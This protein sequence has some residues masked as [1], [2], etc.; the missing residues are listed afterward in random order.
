LEGPARTGLQKILMNMAFI[1]GANLSGRVLSLLLHAVL[2]RFFGP[3]GLGGYF[4]A[5]AVAVY[6]VFIVDFGLSPRLAREGAIGPGR[7]AEEYADALG[8][9]LFTGGLA[10]LG[11]ISVYF[12]LPYEDWVRELCVLLG[13]ASIIRS[14]SYLNESVCRARER[15]DLEAVSGLT[16]AVSFVAFSMVLIVRGFPV[17]TVGFALIAAN[18]LQLVISSILAR[19]LVALGAHLPPRWSIGRAALPYA[20]TSLTFLAFA[21]IDVLL[22]SLIETQE[23]VGRY[24][25]LSRLLL[26]AGSVGALAGAALLPT[27]SRLYGSVKVERFRELVSESVRGVLLLSGFAMLGLI[28]VA[29]PLIVGIYGEAFADLSPMLQMGS[30]YLVF[31]LTVAVLGVI[32]TAVGRQGDRARSMLIGLAVTVVLVL[33]LVPA[34]GILGAVAAMAGSEFVFAGCLALYVG[35]TIEWKKHLRAIGTMILASATSVSL[36]FWIP[37]DLDVW[38]NI[39]AIGLSLSTYVAIVFATGEATRTIR[40]A[41]SLRSKS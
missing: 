24:A 41:F 7:L 38:L 28:V 29:K 26:V 12:V 34:F 18:C 20:T 36:Y 5:A 13:C 19:R 30:V 39:A 25:S 6:F 27:L 11:L 40:F 17:Y 1:T 4:T 31:S 8:L 10:F 2:A 16:G 32:L 14:F 22:I 23:F 3:E 33:T 15:L 21:Q 9:K 35:R 37:R